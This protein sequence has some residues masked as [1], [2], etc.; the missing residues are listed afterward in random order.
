MFFNL[1]KL[2]IILN[3]KNNFNF[4]DLDGNRIELINLK[5]VADIAL[6]D[7]HDWSTNPKFFEYLEFPESKNIEG[8]QQQLD[9]MLSR[10]DEGEHYWCIK[11]K[12]KK[13]FIGTL[14]INEVDFR[15]KF[16]G[17]GY[18]INPEFQG[19]GLASESL[20][21]A[22]NFLFKIL[23]IQKISC[24][25]MSLNLPS[26]NLVKKIGFKQEGLLRNHYLDYKGNMHD[27]IIFGLLQKEYFETRD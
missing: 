4:E 5:K 23:K 18:G 21:L 10:M 2:C 12:E 26:I 24:L 14:R 1:I 27:A 16:C 22:L 3:S 11:L 8:T 9:K 19:K 6:L 13:Q 25:T 20:Q 7:M 17:L 15:K